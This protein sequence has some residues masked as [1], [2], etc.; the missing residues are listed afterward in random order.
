MMILPSS[1]QQWRAN[2]FR[3]ENVTSSNIDDFRKNNA[4]MLAFFQWQTVKCYGE[5]TGH[6]WQ[7]LGRIAICNPNESPG[8]SARR[9]QGRRMENNSCR[10]QLASAKALQNSRSPGRSNRSLDS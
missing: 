5:S 3:R 9:G 4:I 10:E 6:A 8:N 7:S 1:L 2:A